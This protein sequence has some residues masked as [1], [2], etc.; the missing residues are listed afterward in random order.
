MYKRLSTLFLLFALSAALL[1][2]Q[3]KVASID[4]LRSTIQRLYAESKIDSLHILA[5]QI[6]Q[7]CLEENRIK[8]YYDVWDKLVRQYHFT[9]FSER[10]LSESR[11]MLEYA[12]ANKSTYGQA[13]ATRGLGIIMAG[14]GNTT[15]GKNMLQHA[16]TL[17][18][19]EPQDPLQLAYTIIDLIDILN[20]ENNPKQVLLQCN[21]LKN[22]LSHLP[23]EVSTKYATEI[24]TMHGYEAI[25]RINALCEQ[26]QMPEAKKQLQL[27][28]KK[29]QKRPNELLHQAL[30]QSM[31][32]YYHQ[33][34]DYP[35]TLQ[36]I[37]SALE[38]Y[39]KSKYIAGENMMLRNKAEILA[40]MKN[41]EASTQIY[42]EY[43]LQHDSTTSADMSRQISELNAI[44][45]VNRLTELAHK[46]E[47]K[48]QQTIFYIFLGISLLLIVIV[49]LGIMVIHRFRRLNKQL[50]SSESQLRTA[51]DR[52]TNAARMQQTFIQ[53]MTHEIRTPLNSIV[54]FSQ[55]LSGVLEGKPEG[56]ELQEY[57]HIINQNSDLLLRLVGDVLDLSE[58]DSEDTL[59]ETKTTDIYQLYDSL[60]DMF[61]WKTL[62]GVEL[63]MAPKQGANLQ[64][65]TNEL[66]LQQL[67]I[68]LLNNA[69]KFTHK[70]CI[71]LGYSVDEPQNRLYLSVTDTG[72]GIPKEQQETIF[73]RFMKGN[74]YIPGTGLGLPICSTIA[75]R[76]GGEIELDKEYTDGCRFIIALPLKHPNQTNAQAR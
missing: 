32:F 71:L 34:K 20:I 63:R 1:K 17:F 43:V 30:F 14:N 40:Q 58:L 64:I 66:Q 15:E 42:K 29:L 62:P 57:T 4:Q 24:E 27:L 9:G 74:D 12:Q 76:L 36:Y 26:N 67:F 49:I 39:R 3:Q 16:I 54:G 70:G 68:K 50:S 37:D 18:S 2:A 44:Y 38:S 23:K 56:K 60:I 22:A 5:P 8:E 35:S 59:F 48:S 53:N 45:D 11:N 25:Y 69:V 46:Q 75:M 21:L 19:E 73:D 6:M 31:I 72:C 61:Q 10:G 41:F 51:L 28:Q 13:I 55:V 7:R 52:A 65:E 47:L 33:I